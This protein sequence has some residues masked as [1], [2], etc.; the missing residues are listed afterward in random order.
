MLGAA[1]AV[2]WLGVPPTHSAAEEP[3]GAAKVKEGVKEE[4]HEARE[5][6][7]EV[8]HEARDKLEEA[9]GEAH[10][11]LK[12]AREEVKAAGQDI[13]AKLGE[14]REELREGMHNTVDKVLGA[15]DA[16]HAERARE[17]RR[18]A[19]RALHSHWRRGV[20]IP[21]PAREALRHHARRTARLTRIRAL[22]EAA[23]DTKSVERCDKLL[24]LERNHH[25]AR[26]ARFAPAEA[27]AAHDPDQGEV[28]EKAAEEE[29]EQP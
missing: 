8:A 6:V 12:E 17:H 27:P 13:K 14:A 1:L 7:R 16:E 21:P 9:R 29:E 20:D 28:D 15:P 3:S 22:A 10:Q 23:G 26:M 18:G 19:M 5:K 2:L 11:Q 25:Q 4:V 24:E